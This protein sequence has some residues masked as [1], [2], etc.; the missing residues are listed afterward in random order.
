MLQTNRPLKISVSRT[1]SVGT[2]TTLAKVV[3]LGDKVLARV[4]EYFSHCLVNMVSHHGGEVH[5]PTKLWG[6]VFSLEELK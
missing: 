2:E 1:E 6:E 3:E 4:I 5:K